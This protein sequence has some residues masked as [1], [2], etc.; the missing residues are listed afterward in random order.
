RISPHLRRG[1]GEPVDEEIEAFYGRLLAV[2]RRPVVRH[3]RWQLLECRPA[4]DGNESVDGFVAF[5]WE[6]DG[7]RLL[8]AVNYAPHR[9]Q[10][11]VRLPFA[12]LDRRR[13]RLQDLIGSATYERDGDDLAGR[14]LYLD[15]PAW[16][17]SVFSMVPEA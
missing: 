15:E 8:V 1:P 14:G 7:E 4:W 2:L 11:F 12:E 16:Q 10:C 5:S 9:G 13:W 17:A 3:G 6:G